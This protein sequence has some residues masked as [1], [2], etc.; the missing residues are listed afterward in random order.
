[1]LRPVFTQQLLNAFDCVALIIEHEANA[2]DEVDI[3]GTIVAPATAALQ[4]LD[5]REPRLP[6]PKHV[7]WKVQIFRHFANCAECVRAFFHIHALLAQLRL[8]ASIEQRLGRN[9]KHLELFPAKVQSGFAQPMRK[10]TDRAILCLKEKPN[11]WSRRISL[12]IK[13]AAA[14]LSGTTPLRHPGRRAAAHALSTP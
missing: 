5:L 13:V 9:D 12:R 6:E 1:E 7:L 4:R 2:P 10:Q 8:N 14:N 3:L 11:C